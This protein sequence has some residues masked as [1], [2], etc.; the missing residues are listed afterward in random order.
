MT[1]GKRDLAGAKNDFTCATAAAREGWKERK[2][3][4]LHSLS[5]VM[6]QQ[7]L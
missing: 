7:L 1:V 2:S 6:M 3:F 4:R 5:E